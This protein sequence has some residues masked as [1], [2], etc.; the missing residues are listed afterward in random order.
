VIRVFS[1]VENRLSRVSACFAFSNSTSAMNEST[2]SV[3][4]DEMESKR[5]SMLKKVAWFAF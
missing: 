3:V 4:S 1:E 5:F 2:R